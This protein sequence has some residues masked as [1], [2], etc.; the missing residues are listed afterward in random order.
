MWDDDPGFNEA[1]GY[2]TPEVGSNAK[3]FTSWVKTL[4]KNEI[5]CLLSFFNLYQ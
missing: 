5:K 1:I 2:V 3:E 4:L